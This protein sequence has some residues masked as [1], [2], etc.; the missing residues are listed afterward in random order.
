MTSIHHKN[1]AFRYESGYEFLA[2]IGHSKSHKWRNL[3]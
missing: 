3:P 2:D 1:G